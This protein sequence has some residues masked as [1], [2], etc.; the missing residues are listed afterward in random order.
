MLER[1]AFIIVFSDI[2][3]YR[4]SIEDKFA[5]ILSLVVHFMTHVFKYSFIISQSPANDDDLAFI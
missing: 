3:R 5:H 2:Y 4:V 1:S